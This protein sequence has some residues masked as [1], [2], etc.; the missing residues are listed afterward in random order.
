MNKI[1]QKLLYGAVALLVLVGCQRQE[2]QEKASEE[3]NK[4]EPVVEESFE[5]GDTGSL[6]LDVEEPADSEQKPQD[7]SN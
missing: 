1:I 2:P 4:M 7:E 5:G 6:D 3:P